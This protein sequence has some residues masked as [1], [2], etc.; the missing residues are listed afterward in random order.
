MSCQMSKHYSEVR[1]P[2]RHSHSKHINSEIRNN[3][4]NRDPSKDSRDRSRDD[5]KSKY[6]HQSARS[7]RSGPTIFGGNV[8]LKK[9]K[10]VD[11]VSS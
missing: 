2:D 11:E 4:D 5:A 3:R 7:N 10:K 8:L 6:S 1:K 9:E